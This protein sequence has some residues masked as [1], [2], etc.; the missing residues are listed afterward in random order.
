MTKTKMAR[1]CSVRP[2]EIKCE[3]LEDKGMQTGKDED[4]GGSQES[5]GPIELNCNDQ[6]H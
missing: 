1:C 2:P 3:Q 6:E 5:L 4:N